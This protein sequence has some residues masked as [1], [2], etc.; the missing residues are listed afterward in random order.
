MVAMEGSE[1]Q[2]DMVA[3]VADMVAICSLRNLCFYLSALYYWRAQ[4]SLLVV[5]VA[6]SLQRHAISYTLVGVFP[7]KYAY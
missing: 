7:S 3:L 6:V 1:Q 5:A 4:E 2:W